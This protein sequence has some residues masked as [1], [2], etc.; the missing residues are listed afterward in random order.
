M[1]TW[2]KLNVSRTGSK[3]RARAT[4]TVPANHGVQPARCTIPRTSHQVTSAVLATVARLAITRMSGYG[5]YAIGDM[6]IP[7]KG[8]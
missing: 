5:R 6:T 4:A 1:L 8:G 7:A 3:Q 2:P